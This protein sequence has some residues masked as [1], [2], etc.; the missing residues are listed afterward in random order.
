[1]ARALNLFHFDAK[2]HCSDAVCF[3]ISFIYS[4]LYKNDQLNRLTLGYLSDQQ[5]LH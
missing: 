4:F 1:M 5:M 2:E 3:R